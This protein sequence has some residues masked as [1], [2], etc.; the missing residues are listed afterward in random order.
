[1]ADPLVIPSAILSA[2]SAVFG[3]FVSIFIFAIP[4]LIPR[5]TNSEEK[6][7]QRTFVKN[8]FLK[9][10]LPIAYIVFII[11]LFN[12][13][14]LFFIVDKTFQDFYWFEFCSYVI[15]VLTFM[16]MFQFSIQLILYPFYL[17][18]NEDEYKKR[19]LLSTKLLLFLLLTLCVLRSTFS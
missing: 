6:E 11:E 13:L 5:E 16:V 4:L 15:F 18:I 19:C 1:M 3:L 10:F 14:V 17:R 12:S 8:V 2:I 9:K 7:H